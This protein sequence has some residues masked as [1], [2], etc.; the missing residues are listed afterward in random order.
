M[1]IISY[2]STNYRVLYNYT[3]AIIKFSVNMFQT[4]V[5][6]HVCVWCVRGVLCVRMCL[7]VVYVECACMCGVCGVC[8]MF[9]SVCVCV[10]C[11]HVLVRVCVYVCVCLFQTTSY[12]SGI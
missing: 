4:I 8:G 11:V 9:V 2:I 10:W 5:P 6:N 3:Y 12:I 1:Y 7:C